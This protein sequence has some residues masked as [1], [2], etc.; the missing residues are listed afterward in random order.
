MGR[1]TEK[2]RPDREEATDKNT[3]AML[4]IGKDAMVRFIGLNTDEN[5]WRPSQHLSSTAALRF[6][7]VSEQDPAQNHSA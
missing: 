4:D 6:A 7:R 1:L 2:M 5:I 3:D